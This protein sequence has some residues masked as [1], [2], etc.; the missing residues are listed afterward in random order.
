LNDAA[1]PIAEPVV[2]NNS[3]REPRPIPVALSLLTAWIAPRWTARKTLNASLFSAWLVHFVATIG[4]AATIEFFILLGQNN[5]RIGWP[6]LR[7]ELERQVR[8]G[9]DVFREYPA[10]TVLGLL[11]SVVGIELLHVVLAHIAMPW[12]AIDERARDSFGHSLRQTWLRTTHLMF[13]LF[14]LL[15]VLEVRFSLGPSFRGEFMII[16]VV[17][18]SIAWL[19]WA[20]L[21]AIGV[22]RKVETIVRPPLC[23]FCG[24]DLTTMPMESRCPE[25]GRNIVD[26]LGADARPGAPWEFRNH[27][28]L[29]N[30]WWRTIREVIRRPDDFGHRLQA[31][32]PRT[33]YRS[34]VALHLPFVF[35]IAA[36]SVPTVFTVK[37]IQ[38]NQSAGIGSEF[39]AIGAPI[40]GTLCT[41]AAMAV[42]LAGAGKAGFEFLLR[43][44]RNL[45]AVSMQ[46]S[47]YLM[48]YLV[49]WEIFGAATG[50]WCIW[51]VDTPWMK[52]LY[53]TRGVDRIGIC[54]TIWF[55]PNL[56]LGICHLMLVRR[57]TR[58]AR[59]ANK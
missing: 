38:A 6:A 50:I 10:W 43:D 27:I 53:N 22:E 23:E 13:A 34:F 21:R 25:C 4:V 24:Y 59:W 30:A 29:S 26:S 49:L 7:Q 19:V 46:A 20:W 3:A 28:G 54:F 15:V 5:F 33:D 48:P 39:Y 45:L 47:A 56:V 1:I 11:G 8:D 14:L 31:C 40:F 2:P 32:E 9:S 17:L 41:L 57:I 44:K 58:A 52:N 36:A 18:V 12:G 37:A 16:P 55:I 51:L 42:T 35:L